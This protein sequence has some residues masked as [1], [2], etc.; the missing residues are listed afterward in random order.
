MD[1]HVV[2]TP[3]QAAALSFAG[4]PTV[5]VDGVDPFP[6]DGGIGELACRVYPVAERLAG[7]PGVEQI[8][9]VLTM[10]KGS[11]PLGVS[12]PRGRFQLSD[13]AYE[14]SLD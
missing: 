11:G 13:A 7:A 10:R 12:L 8:V 2:W 6:S 9:D 14:D 4:S 5:L 1:V 3:E